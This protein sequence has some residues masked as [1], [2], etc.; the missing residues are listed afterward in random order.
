M[1]Q[2][3]TVS[4]TNTWETKYVT[5]SNTWARKD[6]VTSYFSKYTLC[7]GSNLP[8]HVVQVDGLA[9][10]VEVTDLVKTLKPNRL[11]SFDPC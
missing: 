3:V 10:A 9:E 5:V 2:Y 11:R 8:D 4:T 6:T 7:T 1:S